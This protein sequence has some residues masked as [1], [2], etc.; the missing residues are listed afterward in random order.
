MDALDKFGRFVMDKLRDKAFGYF[1][2]LVAGLWKSE[3]AALL[4][5]ELAR[6]DPAQV[7]LVRRCVRFAVDSSIHDFLFALQG[8]GERGDVVVIVEGENVALKSDGLHG[9]L[10]GEDGWQARFSKFGEPPEVE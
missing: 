9:E 4:Q 1:E 3:D 6:C 7:E 5:E 10:F 2:G 8:A